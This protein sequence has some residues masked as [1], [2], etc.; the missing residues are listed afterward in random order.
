MIGFD[1]RYRFY[2]FISALTKGFSFNWEKYGQV[3]IDSLEIN[4]G[5]PLMLVFASTLFPFF[6]NLQN[7]IYKKCRTYHQSIERSINNPI[8][9]PM[10]PARSNTFLNTECLVPCFTKK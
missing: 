6:N 4:C 2:F 7:N 10:F 9:T 5:S 3:T 1:H 8:V